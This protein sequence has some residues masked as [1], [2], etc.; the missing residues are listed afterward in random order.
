MKK[1]QEVQVFAVVIQRVH[2]FGNTFEL[3]RCTLRDGDK[4]E[5]LM[6]C[7]RL[8]N[9]IFYLTSSSG[10]TRKLKKC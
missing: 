3:Y 5:Y 2:F 1:T 10:K 7:Y 9:R 6:R 4:K 8:S